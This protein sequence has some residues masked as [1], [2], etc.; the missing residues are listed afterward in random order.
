MTATTTLLPAG[1][2]GSL[3]LSFFPGLDI[4]LQDFCIIPVQLACLMPKF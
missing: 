4:C 1:L 3:F 2:I